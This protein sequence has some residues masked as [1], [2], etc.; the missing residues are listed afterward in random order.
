MK[1]ILILEK[2][3]ILKKYYTNKSRPD[4]FFLKVYLFKKLLSYYI[5]KD[6]IMKNNLNIFKDINNFKDILLE[7]YLFLDFVTNFTFFV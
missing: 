1:I 7:K 4:F 2:W 6:I 3:D 5:F